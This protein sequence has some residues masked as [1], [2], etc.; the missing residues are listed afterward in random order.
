MVKNIVAFWVSLI[1]AVG[2]ARVNVDNLPG[3]IV[4]CS[5]AVEIFLNPPKDSRST[6]SWGLGAKKTWSFRL[7]ITWNT[8][9]MHEQHW[10]A[11]VYTSF[12][13]CSQWNFCRIVTYTSFSP[14]CPCSVGYWEKYECGHVMWLRQNFEGWHQL[15]LYSWKRHGGNRSGMRRN[16]QPFWQRPDICCLQLVLSEKFLN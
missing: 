9:W 13:L 6:M 15:R 3:L 12:A 2:I 1:M 11:S 14:E 7:C 4:T 10:R 5:S 16:V 8:L